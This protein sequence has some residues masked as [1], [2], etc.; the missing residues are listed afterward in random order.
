MSQVPYIFADDTGNI[1]LSH[2]DANFANVKSAADF[3]I[4]NVQAN[5]TQVGRLNGLNVLGEARADFF[6]G[7][8][9]QL[10]GVTGTVIGVYPIWKYPVP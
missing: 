10:T 8:G 4:A 2:L 5:I 1:P 6:V 3:V 9:S 7:N